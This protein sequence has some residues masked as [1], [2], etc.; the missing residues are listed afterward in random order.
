MD[1]LEHPEAQ[2]LRHD[3]EVPAAAVR[4]CA[5]RL[6]QLAA[7]Y[8]PDCQRREQRD[9]ALMPPARLPLTPSPSVVVF[10]GGFAERGPP[11][12]TAARGEGGRST[13]FVWFWPRHA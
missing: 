7:R 9:H 2:P 12:K 8:L 4:S 6:E 10:R 3:A 11:R 13:V 1:I 5:A